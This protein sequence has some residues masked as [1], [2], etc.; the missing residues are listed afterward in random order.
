MIYPY[1]SGWV[2]DC[3]ETF[4]RIM[5]NLGANVVGGD[6]FYYY[7]WDWDSCRYSI[8]AGTWY[9]SQNTGQIYGPGSLKT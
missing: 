3:K 6:D 1:R 4:D 5:R 7:V 9:T 2:I 8:Y